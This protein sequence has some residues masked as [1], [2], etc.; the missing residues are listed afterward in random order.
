MFKTFLLNDLFP[1]E[2]KLRNMH[3]KYQE[4]KHQSGQSVND[5][6]KYLDELKT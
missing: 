1:P 5:L 4:A 3:K 6:I 2:I